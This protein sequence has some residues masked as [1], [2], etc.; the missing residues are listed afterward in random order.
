MVTSGP[1]LG[2][3]PYTITMQ[4]R[5][6]SVLHFRS[7][8]Q[9]PKP[10]V[11]IPAL[12]SRSYILDLYE[13][14][15][16]VEFLRTAGYDVY[17]I[18][19]G[20]AGDED[21]RLSLQEI[22]TSYIPRALERVRG[23][24]PCPASLSLVGYCMGGTLALLHAASGQLTSG[25]NLLTLA[26]PV[27]FARGGTLA[28]W[29]QR[30]YLDVKK[31]TTVFGNVP[32]HL[33]EAVFALL[34]PTAKVRAALAFCA[35]A[36]DQSASAAFVAMDRWANDWVPFPGAAAVEWIEWFYQDNR[37]IRNQLCLNERPLRLDA[38]AVPLLCVAAPGDVIVP[39]ASSRALLDAVSSTDKTYVEV[40]G[41]HIGMIAG[42][43]AGRDLWNCVHQWL[44]PRSA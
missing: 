17:L 36:E 21:A 32:A 33:I 35:K 24:S 26:A 23:E 16:F 1:Y 8:R 20:V 5:K 4:H 11:L 34:R 31:I 13:G 19:W 38:I 30:Q 15:S 41:G 18:D 28:K 2:I 44:M 3:S 27:D 39:A 10:I 29:C 25:D 7:R 37:L 42:N 43:N 9:Y 12:I 6:M 40:S 22:V 14:G